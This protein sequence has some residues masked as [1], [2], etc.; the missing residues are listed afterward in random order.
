MHRKV[1]SP[2]GY[3]FPFINTHRKVYEEKIFQKNCMRKKH[4]GVFNDAKKED[5]K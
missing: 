4:A 2:F 5:Y 1:F 3:F